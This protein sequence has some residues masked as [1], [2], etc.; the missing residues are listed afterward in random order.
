MRYWNHFLA[1]VAFLGGLS[2]KLAF[3]FVMF[4]ALVWLV[5]ESASGRQ[6]WRRR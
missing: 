1:M 6:W 3:W 2:L 5:I 4:V